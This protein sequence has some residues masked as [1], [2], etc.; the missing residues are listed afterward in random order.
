MGR[1]SFNY[2]IVRNSYYKKSLGIWGSEFKG[3]RKNR[4]INKLARSK[5]KKIDRKEIKNDFE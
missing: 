4:T 1:R 3:K 5:Q 2:R